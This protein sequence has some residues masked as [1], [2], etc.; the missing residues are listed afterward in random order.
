MKTKMK[1]FLILAT[2]AAATL[3]T[4]ANA[5][6]INFGADM[7]N[8]KHIVHVKTGADKGFIAGVGYSR[9]LPLGERHLALT[10]E[11]TVPW[12]GFDL[13]DFQLKVGAT[14]PLAGKNKW[15]LVGRLMPTVRGIKDKAARITTVGTEVGL[16]GGY[17][18]TR[19]FATAEAGFDWLASSH[20][21]HTSAYRKE[22]F[23]DAKSGWYS[24][25]GGNFYGGLAGGYSLERYDLILRLGKGKDIQG[26][27]HLLP[28]YITAGLNARW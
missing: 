6:E 28:A 13:N 9:I 18:G 19:W 22:V 21:K 26:G 16:M 10:A 5:Q 14:L 2:L 11:A 8:Q 17:Y 7:P 3:A 25:P 15:K 24:N 1:L 23:A 20:I 27:D 12:A 4:E